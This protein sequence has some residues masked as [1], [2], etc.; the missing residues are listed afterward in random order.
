MNPK[1]SDFGMARIFG[2]DQIEANTNRVVGT[3]GY[4][5]PEYA[6]QG[7]ISVKSDVYSFGILMLEIITGRKNSKFLVE[8][9]ASSYLV[10]HVWNLWNE[11]KSIEIVD[12]ALGESYPADE[13]LRCIQIGL[14]CVQEQAI[15]RPTMSAVIFML[16]TISSEPRYLSD[17]RLNG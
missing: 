13:V 1:I 17:S 8:D 4:M 15:D 6:M 7:L 11:G 3:Y 9:S 10:G 16:E 12:K 14:L 5:S 2:G